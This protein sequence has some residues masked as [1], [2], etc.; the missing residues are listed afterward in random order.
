MSNVATPDIVLAIVILLSALIG[1]SRGLVKE[2]L[3]LV[4]WGAA[5]VAALYLGGAVGA[6][7]GPDMGAS[8]R[9]VAGF[10]AVFIAVLLTGAIVQWLFAKLIETTGLTGTDRFLGF[11]FGAARGVVVCTVALIALR[12]FV[13]DTQ[14]WR[15]SRIR[16]ELGK[17]E[18]GVLVL[19]DQAGSLIMESTGPGEGR[20]TPT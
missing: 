15:D 7:L 17:I 2:V 5:F 10:A 6:R 11:L 19:I 20:G 18:A 1:L 16:P 9:G 8:L 14:W 3:S 12:P 13:E 4:I